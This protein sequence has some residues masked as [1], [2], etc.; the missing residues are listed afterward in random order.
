MQL[1]WPCPQ[2]TPCLLV[3]CVTFEK[4]GGTWGTGPDMVK[5]QKLV[6]MICYNIM[7]AYI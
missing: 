2:A 1:L 3:L 5:F 6:L 4:L 7:L